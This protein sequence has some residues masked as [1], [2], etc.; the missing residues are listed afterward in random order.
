MRVGLP[1]LL[2]AGS[3]FLAAAGASGDSRSYQGEA[4]V[5]YIIAPPSVNSRGGIRSEMACHGPVGR[6]RA[7]DP[8]SY[9]R[10]RP[11]GQRHAATHLDLVC[12]FGWRYN[13]SVLRI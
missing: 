11:A 8:L 10:S 3:D 2:S 1:A 4:D 5:A 12:L 9:D 7:G 13:C 6:D